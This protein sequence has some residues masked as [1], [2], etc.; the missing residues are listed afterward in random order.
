MKISINNLRTIIR[1]EVRKAKSATRSRLRE[2]SD[3]SYVSQASGNFTPISNLSLFGVYKNPAG[4]EISI[5]H[6]HPTKAFAI[7]DSVRNGV[8]TRRARRAA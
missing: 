7:F 5:H 2:D 6:I 8:A 4:D 3:A 1:E